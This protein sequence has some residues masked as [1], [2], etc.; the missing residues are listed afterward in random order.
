MKLLFR[1][2]G[3]PKDDNL[4]SKSLI[5]SFSVAGPTQALYDL[6]QLLFIYQVF[7]MF[8]LN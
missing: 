4:F 3:L 6:G 7:E 5:I 2:M 1:V 8:F